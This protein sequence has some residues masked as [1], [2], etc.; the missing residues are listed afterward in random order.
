MT[1]DNTTTEAGSPAEPA[2]AV[3]E[4]PRTAQLWLIRHGETAWSLSGQHTGVTDLD[5]TEHGVE[6]AEALRPLLSTM[7]PA[8]VLSSPRSRAQRTAAL[9]GVAVDDVDP[10]M[11]EWDYGD[12]EGLTSAEIAEIDPSWTI[13]RGHTPN[14]ETPAQVTARVDRVLARADR[15][16]RRWAGDP[17]RTRSHQPCAGRPLA[18]TGRECRID[19]RP[20]YRGSV[21]ARRRARASGH[22]AVE[23]DQPGYGVTPECP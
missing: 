21:P 13:W 10:D 9:T 22:N 4:L 1:L 19:V 16:S 23:H 8:L 18:R 3:A 5:L 12:Y 6:Q 7:K 15:R 2:S 20:R 17:L 14:G 11:A